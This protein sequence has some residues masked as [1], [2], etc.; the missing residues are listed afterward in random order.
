MERVFVNWSVLFLKGQMFLLLG[1]RGTKS[2]QWVPVLFFFFCR[3]PRHS[4]GTSS[5]FFSRGDLWKEKQWTQDSN[6]PCNVSFLLTVWLPPPPPLSPHVFYAD[7]CVCCR[8]AESDASVASPSPQT[9]VSE[10]RAGPL[11]LPPVARGGRPAQGRRR[12]REPAGQQRRGRERQ[13]AGE[14]RSRNCS[15]VFPS[16]KRC[17]MHAF[18]FFKGTVCMF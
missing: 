18:L 7:S 5:P 11:Q 4:N 8:R 9:P 16:S 1:K 17:Q 13:G 12:V 10:L 15:R 3:L 6:A 14:D 2:L